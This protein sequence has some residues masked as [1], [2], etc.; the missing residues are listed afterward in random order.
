MYSSPNVPG[1]GRTANCASNTEGELHNLMSNSFLLFAQGLDE[2]ALQ[3]A[4]PAAHPA[5]A[6]RA[7]G[8]EWRRVLV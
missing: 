2:T 5:K 4:V 6:N 3:R 8:M 7:V 1:I